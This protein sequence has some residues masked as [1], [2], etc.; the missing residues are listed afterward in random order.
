M[1]IACL[2]WGSLVWDP[3]ELPIQRHWFDD[4]P[5]APVEFTRQS[6]DGRI[7]LVLDEY[8]RP[9]RLLWAPMTSP[10]IEKAMEGLKQ[11]EG[12]TAED[13]KSKVGRWQTGAPAPSRIPSL[14]AWAE[15]HGLD[16]VIWTALGPQYK[17]AG[18]STPTMERPSISWVLDHLG[19]LPGP[20]RKMAEKYIRCAPPQIDTE[21]RRRVEAEL[22][23]GYRRC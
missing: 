4:G 17:R 12:I 5:F 10:D 2:A 16:A 3:R 13:W 7:T 14:P 11:R 1:I 21:Y 8:A 20:R 18:E 15:A 23:W 22:G 9:V 19:S 6:K